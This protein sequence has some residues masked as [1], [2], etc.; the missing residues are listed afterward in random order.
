M[1]ERVMRRGLAGGTDLRPR[2]S[3]QVLRIK[4]YTVADMLCFC[5]K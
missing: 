5:E 4:S 2:L 1:F 3:S